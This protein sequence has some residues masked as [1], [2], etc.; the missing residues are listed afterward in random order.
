[1][2]KLIYCELLKL[3]RRPLIFACL[4]LSALMPLALN[5]LQPDAQTG[6]DAV[7]NHLSALIQVSAYF[8]LMPVVVILAASLLF[9]EQDN[10]TLK[11]LLVIP[12]DK[13]KLAVAKMLI[14]LLFSVLFMAV[15]GLLCLLM[16]IL[17][18][19]Q[20]ER[21][22]P[23]FFV[24]LGQGIIMWAGA[25]PCVLLVAAFNSSYIISVIITFFY[26]I[27]NYMVTFNDIFTTQ[28]FGLNPGTLL[29]GPLS[30]RWHFQF[31]DIH[32]PSEEMTRLLER[33]S[34][35]FMNTI[36]AFG[37]IAVETVLFLTLIAI[38]YKHQKI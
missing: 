7:T 13:A 23:L 30:F 20:P 29:P 3:R 33:V 27:M 25:L 34:P 15:G 16:I 35:Y 12:V 1:M 28:P 2:L 24:G 19:W 9:Q 21:F 36:Q 14:L 38:V 18:G 31:F 22:L 8:L 37:V 6:A 10:D 32:N 11:N 17:Q 26:T 5:L 4:P